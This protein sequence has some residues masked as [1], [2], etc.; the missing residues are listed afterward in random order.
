MNGEM[1]PNVMLAMTLISI[2][3]TTYEKLAELWRRAGVDEKILVDIQKRL[4]A[5]KAIWQ[6]M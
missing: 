3:V 6:S 2:G 1:D 4:A 5:E